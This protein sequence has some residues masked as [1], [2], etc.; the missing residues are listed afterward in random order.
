MFF[1]HAV[2]RLTNYYRRHGFRASVERVGLFLSQ[3]LTSGKMVVF[4]WDLT[5]PVESF[6]WPNLRDHLTVEQ[7]NSREEIAASDWNQI[8]DFWNRKLTE[9]AFSLRLQHG[10]TIWL[11]RSEGKLAGYMWSV[12]GRTLEP[13]Y[14]PLGA[15]DAMV[16]DFLVFPEYRGRRF[17]P[18]LLNY[19][20]KEMRAQNMTRAHFDVAAWNRAS[21][22]GTAKTAYPRHMLGIARKRTFFGRTF[23]QWLPLPQLEAERFQVLAKMVTAA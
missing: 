16:Y 14:Y 23:V 4:Y 21:L 13:Y 7:K 10:A 18:Y 22:S 3:A 8:V 6:D 20:L 2:S 5:R 1:F 19:V 17:L 12:G 9:P 11:L 15:G